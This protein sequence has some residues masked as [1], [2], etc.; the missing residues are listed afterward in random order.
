MS[1]PPWRL[2]GY[3]YIWLYRLPHAFVLEHAG[4]EE[5]QRQALHDTLG[6]MMWVHYQQSNAGAYD[7]WLLAPGRFALNRQRLFSISTIYVST[8]A[9]AQ[10]GRANWGIPKQVA[11]F[12]QHQNSHGRA[13][14]RVHKGER[15]A[16]LA[17][18]QPFGPRF[19]VSSALFPL[20]L[21]QRQGEDLLITQPRAHGWA[22]L[23]RVHELVVA[24]E[25]FPDVSPFRPLLVIAVTAFRMVFPPPLRVPGYFAAPTQRAAS[26]LHQAG[27]A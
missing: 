11:R 20:R 23:C 19:P 16:M 10:W 15:L 8:E 14:L 27:A 7:E 6:T 9:S 1:A 18:V 22:R 24:P 25:V 26:S 13:C 4:L 17:C 12:E 21:G 2:N 3:G 5:W